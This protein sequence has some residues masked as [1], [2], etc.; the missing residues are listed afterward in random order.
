MGQAHCSRSVISEF[1]SDGGHCPGGAAE[2][3]WAAAAQVAEREG[4]GQEPAEG[5]AHRGLDQYCCNRCGAILWWVAYHILGGISWPRSQLH[6]GGHVTA[7]PCGD[8]GKLNRQGSCPLGCAYVRVIPSKCDM[9]AAD[10]PATSG[11]V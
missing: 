5:R 3:D 8:V 11:C 9:Y 1:H 7:L 4:A 2:D 10:T 6:L